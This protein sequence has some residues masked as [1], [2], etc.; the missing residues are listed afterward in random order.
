MSR[1][2]VWAVVSY[3]P[4]SADLIE[5]IDSNGYAHIDEHLDYF[6]VYGDDLAPNGK[7]LRTVFNE[8]PSFNWGLKDISDLPHPI[9]SK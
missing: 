7:S 9:D 6:Y 2:C 4:S 5:G 3:E 8:T 1:V